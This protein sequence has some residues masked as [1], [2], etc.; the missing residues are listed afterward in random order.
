MSQSQKFFRLQPACLSICLLALALVFGE[1]L[2]AEISVY[3]S[4]NGGATTAIVQEINQAKKQILVQ[5]YSFTSAPIAAALIAAKKRG[6]DVEA[7]LDKSNV[8]RSYSATT[9]LQ[10]GGIPVFIDG[11][12]SIAHSKIMIIDNFEVITG[13]FNFTKAAEYKNA[14]NVLIIRNN[15]TLTAKFVG[16]FYVRMRASVPVK[17]FV[18]EERR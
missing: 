4:P 7:I 10:N 1:T 13:S 17:T 12:V 5:A 2:E 15:P 16:N 9:F 8:T 3:F 14:E 11:G 6:I 18:I